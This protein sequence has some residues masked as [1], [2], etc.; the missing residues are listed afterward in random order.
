LAREQFGLSNL[1]NHTNAA[2]SPVERRTIRKVQLRLIPFLFLLYVVA[3]VDRINVGFAALTMNKDLG[4]TSQQYGIVAGVFFL[5]YFLFEVPSNLILH[6]VGARV[7]ISRI[8]LSWGVI[9]TLTG[10]VQSVHQLYAARFLLG[11]AEAG[12]YPGIV[13]YLTYWI[14]QREQ[15]RT[16]ALFLTGYPVNSVLGAPISGFLLEHAHWLGLGSWRWLLILEG[17][18]AIVLG[19]LTYFVLPNRPS[20]AGFLT[21]EEK[22]W[23]QSELAREEQSKLQQRPQTAMEGLR[24][25]R[26]WHL[27]AIYFGMMLGGYTMAFWMPQVVKSLSSEYS[28]SLVGYL[29]MIPYLVALA[30]MIL[31]GRSSDR[32]MERRLHVAVSLL[33]GGVAFIGLGAV[34]AP[35]LSIVLFALLATGYC[36]SLSPF[37]AMPSEFLTGYSAASGIALIN[38]TGNL[39][40]FAG[41]YV[42]GF[43]RERTGS[44]FGGLAF[45]GFFMIVAAVLAWKLPK[46][47]SVATKS[48][49]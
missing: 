39:G 6:R 30:G 36:S 49:A 48:E 11:L 20:E 9:A 24:N 32:K 33:I 27:V 18:P 14:P 25:G 28:Y 45:A 47:T 12:Y 46:T 38:A 17:L 43:L 10:L 40:G 3:M 7:W 44:L 4:A 35:A 2:S 29:V 16:L 5:G 8:L 1:G 31:V 13:L 15:A 19:I 21:R 41:P 42:V 34:H 22:E 37:W 23:L 26:V